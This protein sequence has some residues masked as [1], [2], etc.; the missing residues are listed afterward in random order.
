[1]PET[2]WVLGLPLGEALRRL[3]E[4]GLS[5]AV[6]TTGF[7]GRERAERRLA[8]EGLAWDEERVVQ[9]RDTGGGLELVVSPAC[10]RE[11]A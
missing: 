10:R 7:T 2:P 6:R 3:R 5:A 8:R 11:Q 1:M 4:R 9:V